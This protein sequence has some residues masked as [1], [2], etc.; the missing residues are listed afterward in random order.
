[1]RV[2][3]VLNKPPCHSGHCL[4]SVAHNQ[5]ALALRL[6]P[7][8][9]PLPSMSDGPAFLSFQRAKFRTRL[10]FDLL[11]TPG[12]MWLRKS[13]GDLWQ[14]GLTRFAQ[15]MLGEPVDLDFEAKPDAKV[16]TGDVIGW[17]EG[18]KAVTDLFSPIDGR[19]AGGNPAFDKDLSCIHD[20]IYERGWIFSIEGQPGNDCVD[21][22]GYAGFL[23]VNID[24]M[25]AT[26]SVK[27]E[28]ADSAEESE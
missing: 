12:H 8:H 26:D 7:L 28:Q 19:F 9:D 4:A 17:L 1:M 24:R 25:L 2:S 20:S 6:D 14:V 11:Y 22:E 3:C 21:A 13:E 10:P 15:R 27:P 18:F 16:Q 5:N 23:E